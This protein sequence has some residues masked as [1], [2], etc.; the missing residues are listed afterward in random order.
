MQ[1]RPISGHCNDKALVA[2]SDGELSGIRLAAT[3][4]HLAVCRRCRM[5]RA[6]LKCTLCN[7]RLIVAP[8]AITDKQPSRII[9]TAHLTI[10]ATD[11]VRL[12]EKRIAILA[13]QSN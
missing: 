6:A 1:R 4:G 3:R 13:G 10:T 11:W 8:K 9:A 12:G 2:Y 5:R 7:G